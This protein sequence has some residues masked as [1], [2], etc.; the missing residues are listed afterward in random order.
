[1][2]HDQL[3]NRAVS[4]SSWATDRRVTEL[5]VRRV[6]L[7]TGRPDGSVIIT[8]TKL[9]KHINI[10]RPWYAMVNNGEDIVLEVRW[11]GN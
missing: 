4:R 5:L 9:N 1:M 3:T 11:H 2:V 10:R 6:L 8:Y 7:D